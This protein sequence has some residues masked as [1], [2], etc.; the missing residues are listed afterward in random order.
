MLLVVIVGL[1][2]FFVAGRFSI[3]SSDEYQEEN[4]ALLQTVE[5]LSGANKELVKQKDFIENSQ[6]IDLQATKDSR[7]SLTKL[8]SELSE[9]KEQLAFYQRVVAPETLRKGLYISSFDLKRDGEKKRYRYQLVVAQGASQ[10]RALKGR[11]TVSIKG[12]LNGK[13]KT[14]SL[15]DV[16]LEKAKSAKFSFRYYEILMGEI[17]L[18][19]EF[20]PAYIKVKISPSKKNAKVVEQQWKWDDIVSHR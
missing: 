19:D 7:R 20:V 10:K 6:K 13:D 18:P 1:L 16:A 5:D 15:K 4:K 17:Q 3:K 14:L 2:L 12:R 8:L 9:V 11:Y